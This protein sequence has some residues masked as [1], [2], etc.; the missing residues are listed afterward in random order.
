M[1]PPGTAP[2]CRPVAA[3]VLAIAALCALLGAAPA[4]PEAAAGTG[5]GLASDDG[6][7]TGF[8]ESTCATIEREAKSR[9]LP[10]PFL[11]R[12]IWKESRFDPNAVSPKGA[13]GIVQ[14][15]PGTARERGLADPFDAASA[16]AA[17]A[18]YLQELKYALGNLGLAAAGYNAGPDRVSRWRAGTATLPWETRDF[19]LSIT[20][21]TAEQWTAPQVEVPDL[22]LSE[23]LPFAEA[24]REFAARARPLPGSR[25]VAGS[26]VKPWGVLVASHFDEGRL[27]ATLDRLRRAHPLIAG[28]EPLDIARRPNRARGGRL[29]YEAMLGVDDRDAGNRLCARLTDDGGVCMVVRN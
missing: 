9:A 8:L 29:M 21:L 24:C 15:M 6:Q 28:H 13:A 25:L 17:S 22:S 10:P 19:V 20:G 1:W 11:A 23:T 4:A 26:P 7:K 3:G 2:A 16:L 5:P 12:L 27:L 14:F 18:A